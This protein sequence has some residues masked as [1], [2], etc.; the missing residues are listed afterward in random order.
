MASNREWF[1][2]IKDQPTFI[3]TTT[4]CTSAAR[5]PSRMASWCTVTTRSGTL[6]TSTETQ[7]PDRS[8]MR[9]VALGMD[10]KSARS[11]TPVS[12]SHWPGSRSY[13]LE[14]IK[15]SSK[16]SIETLKC[17]CKVVHHCTK[18][19][20]PKIRWPASNN[21][22]LSRRTRSAPRRL[23]ISDTTSSGTRRELRDQQRSMINFPPFQQ[24]RLQHVPGLL[25]GRCVRGQG[26]QAGW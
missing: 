5:T 3:V 12:S 2:K 1:S 21:I 24:Q 14:I 20:R 6:W 9:P 19:E 22:I 7:S 8:M 4:I 13:L 18:E 26:H 25:H 10:G 16:M 11:S 23:S 15:T 17:D